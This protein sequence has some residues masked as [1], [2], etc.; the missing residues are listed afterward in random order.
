MNGVAV[1][2]G[3]A[4]GIGQ[5]IVQALRAADWDV[6]VL[7]LQHS[8]HASMSV[9]CDVT[10]AEAVKEA[11]QEVEGA[12]GPPT[13]LVCAAGIVSEIPL[14]DLP[15]SEWKRVI[16][17]SLTSAFLLSRSIL[18]GMI[19]AGGGS[20]VTLS[21]GWG[22]KGYPLGAHYAAAKSGVEALTKS[23]A[24][25]YATRGIRCNSVAPGPVRTAMVENNADFDEATKSKI[26]PM[27]RIGEVRDVVAPIMF[28]LGDGAAYIT[29]QVLHVNGGML[30]P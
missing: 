24:L 4:G 26:I 28:L 23:I 5:G 22:R 25:E 8:S 11:V 1:V 6:A 15:E 12:L 16:D 20:I 3:G 9:K 19:E 10:D 29:G 7:D 17:V 14:T 21:S 2:S 30:M 13:R 27:G 18:P